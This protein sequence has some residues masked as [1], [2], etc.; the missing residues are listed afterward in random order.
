MMEESKEK[1]WWLAPGY[2]GINYRRAALALSWVRQHPGKTAWE[3]SNISGIVYAEL[4]K[5][6][7]KGRENGLFRAVSEER[8]QGGVRY[9]Y[10]EG[11]AADALMALWKERGLLREP[12]Q[13]DADA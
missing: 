8:N 12:E 9:R 4:S 11:E 1:A 13:T 3:L 5:G 10:W 2:T 7:Q 6:L